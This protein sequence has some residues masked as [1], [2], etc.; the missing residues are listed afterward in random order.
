MSSDAGPGGSAA[1]ELFT[2][3]GKRRKLAAG[4][5]ASAVTFKRPGEEDESSDDDDVDN[6]GPTDPAALTPNGDTNG[7]L[8]QAAEDA[9]KVV[10][11]QN[12]VIHDSD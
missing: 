3:D 5:G 6:E 7:A 4:G 10:E 11:E 9:P 2:A 12:V 1:P 8:K